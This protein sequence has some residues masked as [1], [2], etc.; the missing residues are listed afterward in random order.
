MF[1]VN[2]KAFSGPLDLLLKLLAKAELN[3]EEIFVSE[4]TSEYLAFVNALE[5]EDP[6]GV[7][8]FITVAAELI[9]IKSRRMLPD[10]PK[11]EEEEEEE[12]PEQAFI[13]RLK[14]Y[15]AC[16]QNAEVLKDK[17]GEG[18]LLY[19]RLPEE[20]P[21]PL[22]EAVF[23]DSDPDSLWAAFQKVL[24]KKSIPTEP[25]KRRVI[26]DV[27]TIR[28]QAGRLRS[29]LRKK[30]SLKFEELFAPDADRMEKIV[31]FMALLEM[32]ARGEV[33]VTQQIAFGTIRIQ[34]LALKDD[35]EEQYMDEESITA[36]PHNSPAR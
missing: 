34:A 11:S 17:Y 7:S 28:R 20:L 25:A 18:A 24:S 8:E 36:A 23:K 16:Q 5:Q 32:M 1:E 10:P 15:Q 12:D 3:I 19:T 2:Q 6:D 22:S 13:D 14:A 29:A 35:A 9:Y 26:K 33:H 31:T 27:Y 4:I 30:G 21:D